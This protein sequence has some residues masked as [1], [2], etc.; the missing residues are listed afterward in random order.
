VRVGR[1]A[2]G[3]AAEPDRTE[4]TEILPLDGFDFDGSEFDCSDFESR[5]FDDRDF[6]DR[7]FDDAGELA[8]PDFRN[9]SAFGNE[10]QVLLAPEL[11]DLNDTDDL[12]P[13]PLAAP[14]EVMVR[15]RVKTGT[16]LR[17]DRRHDTSRDTFHDALHDTSV[18]PVVPRGGQ[19]RKQ[20][21]SATRGRLLISAMAAGAAAA[22]AHSATGH[23]DTPRTEPV[24]TANASPLAGGSGGDGTR[25]VQVIAV[26]PASSPSCVS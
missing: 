20:P 18:I 16:D 24:L 7:D 11:D 3:W 4:V 6:D 19:H 23:A 12:S 10:A 21:T 1:A 14:T 25:G 22:A 5:D 13:L 15:V 26:R 9:G 8:D 2:G 17:P